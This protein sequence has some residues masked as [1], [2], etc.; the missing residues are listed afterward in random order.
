MLKRSAFILVALLV[1][2]VSIARAGIVWQVDI[3]GEHKKG[4]TT[5]ITKVYA[6]AGLV[7]E[8]YIEVKGEAANKMKAKGMWWLYKSGTNTVYIVDPEE[9]TYMGIEFDSLMKFMGALSSIL[10]MKITNLKSEIKELDAEKLLEYNCRH[11][12]INS[13][14]DMEMKILMMKVKSHIE[15]DKAIW[16]TNELPME[17]VSLSFREQ[18]FKTGMKDLDSLIRQEMA[19]QKDLG[20]I[21]KSVETQITSDAKGKET[22]KSTTTMTVSG[23][24]VK[25]LSADLF[26]IPSDYKEISMGS[27]PGG[28]E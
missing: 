23:V 13:S 20:F 4:E 26:K 19:A 8:E 24:E 9:K 12:A 10:S 28:G 18:S 15:K 16:A 17:E 14:Y 27:L 11:Y 3:T 5:T 2:S 1:L 25:D 7:R 22:D 21:L 6:Q